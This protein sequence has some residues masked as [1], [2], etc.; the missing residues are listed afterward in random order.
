MQKSK[1]VVLG[2]LANSC[3]RT[4]AKGKGERERYTPLNAEFQRTAR[5][6]E[7]AFLNEQ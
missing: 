3:D 1:T 2:G 7:K 5:R 6:G 4:E